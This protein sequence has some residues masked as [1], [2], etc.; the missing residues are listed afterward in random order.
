MKCE[1]NFCLKFRG[2]IDL[3]SNAEK[4]KEMLTITAF[5]MFNVLN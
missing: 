4:K 5:N 2:V 3:D 1:V